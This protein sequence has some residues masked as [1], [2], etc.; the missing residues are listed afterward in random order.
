MCRIMNWSLLGDHLHISGLSLPGFVG[1][2]LIGEKRKKGVS[3]DLR[4]VRNY[5]L[6]LLCPDRPIEM[7]ICPSLKPRRR[8][9]CHP[10]PPG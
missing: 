4:G 9:L 2:D 8:F 3:C 6:G 5:P 1:S 7:E 10:K